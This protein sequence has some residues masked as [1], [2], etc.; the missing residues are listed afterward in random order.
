MMRGWFDAF[1]ENGGPTLYSHSNRTAVTADVATL[2][3]YIVFV[4]L[5]LAFVIIFP[6]VRRQRFTTFTSVTLSLFVG[7]AILVGQHGS[8]WH[9]AEVEISSAYR[10]FSKEKVMGVLGVHIG[11][12]SVN[13]TLKAMPIYNQSSDID[14]NER[15]HWIGATQMKEDY[16]AALVKGLPFPILTVGEYFTVD[17][18]GFC[19]GRNY[20]E[21]GYYTSI[22][23]WLEFLAGDGCRM[24]L[25]PHGWS[26]LHH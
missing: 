5:F 14:Y 18:E 3:L 17:A 2:T 21:A 11:L 16:H 25:C 13:V 20:R 23:L 12:N 4:T 1:R 10:A 6:G 22:F 7:T 19:W 9:T 24:S 26:C 8:A 15:F